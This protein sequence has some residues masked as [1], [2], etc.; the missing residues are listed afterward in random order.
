MSPLDHDQV[1]YELRGHCAVITIDRPERRN[2]VDGATA[3]ALAAAYQRWIAD[4][5]AKVMILTGAGSE[6]FCAG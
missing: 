3:D 5:E 2:A 4:E 1:S 6:A